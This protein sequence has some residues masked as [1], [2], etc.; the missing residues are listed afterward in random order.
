MINVTEI[1]CKHCKRKLCE[2]AG[3]FI[4]IIKCPKCKAMNEFKHDL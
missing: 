3:K 4:F 1:R 2:A